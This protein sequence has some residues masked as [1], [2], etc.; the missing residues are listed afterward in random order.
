MTDTKISR[1]D[2][3][4]GMLALG[5]AGAAAVAG[6]AF[7]ATSAEAA[8]PH[9]DAA[10]VTLRLALHQLNVAVPDKGGYRV[11]AIAAVNDAIADVENG[12]VWA[13]TH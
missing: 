12:I 3:L 6:T 4:R 9:M 5:A 10:L 7:T 2:G 8:Q 11:K 1:R 13:K